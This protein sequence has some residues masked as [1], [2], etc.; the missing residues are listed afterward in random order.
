MG[1]S[2][3][4]SWAFVSINFV[5]GPFRVVFFLSSF[6]LLLLLLVFL[7]S[8]SLNQILIKNV[9]VPKGKGHLSLLGVAGGKAETLSRS[10]GALGPKR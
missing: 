8:L 3:L 5:N 10:W 7:T 6:L 4:S 1:E 2:S 9:T